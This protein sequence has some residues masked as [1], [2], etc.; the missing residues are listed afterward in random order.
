MKNPVEVGIIIVKPLIIKKTHNHWRCKMRMKLTS[1]MSI[2]EI[3]ARHEIADELFKISN[4]LDAHTEV[5]VKELIQ[6]AS[7]SLADEGQG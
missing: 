2:Y 5:N 7:V 1:Q 6:K 4:W 3:F